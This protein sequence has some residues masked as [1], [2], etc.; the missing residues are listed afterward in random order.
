[1]NR[2][3]ITGDYF[4]LKGPLAKKGYDWRWHSF[5]AEHAVTGERK[6]FYI[7]YF[8]SNPALAEKQPVIIC[9]DPD[10][11][12]AGSRTH[13]DGKETDKQIACD[14]IQTTFRAK[15]VR[16]KSYFNHFFLFT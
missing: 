13:F 5:A 10:A 16:I 11:Q 8:L 12:R 7:E 1:M 14:V 4:M 9:N 2:S 6:A 15:L 3:D